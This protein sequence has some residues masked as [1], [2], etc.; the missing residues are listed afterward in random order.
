MIEKKKTEII[1]LTPEEVVR[2]DSLVKT[3]VK[4]QDSLELLDQL[5]E[6]DRLDLFRILKA[7][8]NSGADVQNMLERKAW[9]SVYVRRPVSVEEFVDSEALIGKWYR[10]NLYDCWKQEVCDVVNSGAIEWV[11]SGAIGIGKTSAAMLGTMYKLY[12]VTCMRDPCGFFGC[13]NIVFGLFSVSLNLAQDVEA[14]MLIT[15]LKESEYFRQVVGVSEETLSGRSTRGMI[16]KFPNNIKFAFG[17]QG[18]HAL[19]QDVYSAIVDEIAFSKSPGARQ[20]RDLYNSVKTR[21]ESRFMTYSGRVPG[22]VCLTG[23]TLVKQWV[24]EPVTISSLVGKDCLVYSYDI[25]DQLVAVGK[26][27]SVHR[28][29]ENVDILRINFKDGGTIRCTKDHPILSSYA[30]YVLAGELEAGDL[31]QGLSTSEEPCIIEVLSVVEDGTEDVFDMEVLKYHNFAVQTGYGKSL[32]VHNCVASSANTEGDFLDEHLK[33]SKAKDKVHV[34]SFALYQVKSYPGQR[35]RVLIGN[36]FHQSRLLDRVEKTPDGRKRVVALPDVIPDECRVEEVPIAW[37]ER[38]NEDLERSIRDI[39][40]ISLYSASP[41]FGNREKLQAMVDLDRSHPFTLDEPTISLKDDELTL[42]SIFDR[43]AMFDVVDSYRNTY[44][45]KI[46][47]GAPRFIHA[48]LA[49][50]GDSVGLACS[51]LYGFKKVERPD[52][53]GVPLPVLLPVVYVDFVLKVKPPKGSEIDFSKITSFI[54]YLQGLGL[55][56]GAITFDRFQSSYHQQ[57]FKK[58]GLESFE[59]SLDRTPT[60]YQSLKSGITAGCVNIYRYQALLDELVSL[61]MIYSKDGKSAKVDHPPHGCFAGETLVRMADGCSMRF[62]DMVWSQNHYVLTWNGI[63]TVNARAINPHPTKYTTDI[64]AVT[65]NTGPVIR[66]TPDHQWLLTDGSY[67]P[68]IDLPIGANLRNV[69]FASISVVSVDSLKLITPIAV[70]DL[71]VE[72]TENFALAAG[73]FV[74]NSKDVADA[75]AGSHYGVVSSGYTESQL[76][77][78]SALEAQLKREHTV[79]HTSNSPASVLG[80]DWIMSDHPDFDRMT[81][82]PGGMGSGTGQVR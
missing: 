31:L 33:N 7:R 19:G 34:S 22:L 51:H 41:F 17:S 43:E 58:A 2:F 54:F 35:F 9:E 29:G 30:T 47:P 38:Y 4:T 37:Y 11:L 72:V 74:H 67:V 36:K 16:L 61:Q 10:E 6:A 75:L 15:R 1:D 32:F 60:A 73:P 45:P 79:R 14:N 53:H 20:V 82:F 81:G 24:G 71:T 18:S 55:P 63:N 56:I 68:A 8:L 76:A 42:E 52:R 13:T 70:Y 65:L 77:E 26:G 40:G 59:I 57:I 80:T 25:D 21:L 78:G 69:D 66:C 28:T 46:N 49:L 62:E 27:V 64:V 23:D 39:S 48:D 44:R 12:Q 3:L 50:T 5:N